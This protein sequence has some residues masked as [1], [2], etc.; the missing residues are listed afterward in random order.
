MNQTS[1]TQWL[2]GT[3]KALLSIVMFGAASAAASPGAI[4]TTYPDGTIVNGNL[5]DAKDHVYL[6]GGPQNSSGGGG[7]PDGQ[8]YFQVTDPSGAVLLSQDDISCRIAN[9]VGGVI[10][11]EERRV[12]RV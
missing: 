6:N 8:Y 1:R 10:R 3:F 2:R 4:W 5:Y 11:S 7:I 12:E 9:V